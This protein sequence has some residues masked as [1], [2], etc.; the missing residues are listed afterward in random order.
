MNKINE[1]KEFFTKEVETLKK[2]N[3]NRNAGY[4]ERNE[5]DKI[6]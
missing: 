6:F 2:Q 4:K 1:Q 5:R 3:Q